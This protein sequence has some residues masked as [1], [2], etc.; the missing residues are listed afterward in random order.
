LTN[1]EGWQDL[2][3]NDSFEI[4]NIENNATNPDT[5]NTNAT[6]NNQTNTTNNQTTNNNQTNTTDP[7]N[8][9]TIQKQ[10]T[11]EYEKIIFIPNHFNLHPANRLWGR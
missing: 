5:N 11:L 4:K 2:E 9:N 7:I 3:V 6:N 10:T 8:S 1:V